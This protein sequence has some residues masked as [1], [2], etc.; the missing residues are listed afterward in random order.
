MPYFFNSIVNSNSIFYTLFGHLENHILIIIH[1]N[2]IISESACENIYKK[3]NHVLIL[4]YFGYLTGKSGERILHL[5][6][7]ILPHSSHAFTKYN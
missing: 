3:K 1:F 7:V 6:L 4:E 2:Y 5:L